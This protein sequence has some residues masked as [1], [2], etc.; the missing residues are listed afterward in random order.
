MQ[1]FEPGQ[2]LQPQEEDIIIPESQKGRRS[3]SK[4]I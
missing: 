4:R 2:P 3:G 1:G